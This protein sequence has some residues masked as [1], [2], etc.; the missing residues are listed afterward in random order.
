MLFNS[1]LFIK[2][3]LPV[4]FLY[5]FL[6]TK[7]QNRLLLLASYI[8]YGVWDWRFLPL[9][10]IPTV[11][12]YFCGFR[13]A[14]CDDAKQKKLYLLISIGVNLLVLGFFKY[15]NFFLSNI[16]GLLNLFGISGQSW[17]L[18]I[19]LPLGISFYTFK[20][21]SY[22]IDIYRGNLKPVR[23]LVDYALFV[24]F[25]IELVAGPIDRARN[26]LPQISAK[27][28]LSLDQVGEGCH[29][30]FWG[31]F[32]KVF[33]AGNLA[34]IVDPVFSTSHDFQGSEVL[35][36]TYAFAFQLLCDFSGYSN[37]A[38]GIGKALGFDIM[39]NFRTPFFV[40]NIQEFWKHW[41]ISLSSWV[42]DYVYMPLFFRTKKIKS[43]VRIHFVTLITM[44]IMGLW[45][46]A[47]WTFVV[48]GM[49]HGWL[50]VGYNI[51]RSSPI[52][53][54]QPRLAAFKFIW[55][56]I[57]VFF[58]FQLVALGMLLF[59]C[60]SFHQFIVMTQSLVYK[61]NPAAI[62]LQ[63]WGKLVAIISPFLIIQVGQRWSG[64]LMFLQKRNI[65]IKTF[66]YAVMTYLITGYGILKAEEFIYFQF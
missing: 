30:F 27:R 46:G 48:W 18:N 2:F 51:L 10:W 45:H 23:N 53:R 12:D 4:F 50:L 11:M 15:F 32:Q 42:N 41:H 5:L 29:L 55:T 1:L 19:I 65:F 17:S 34:R 43:R 63:D 31:L 47:S 22:T 54:V 56:I 38:Q 40:T 44:V 33:V 62:Q 64:D 26:L 58:V 14:A 7:W 8:F 16:Y 59:R 37:M 66:S 3:I 6:N 60:E 13:I 57:R 39:V 52:L 28:K 36:V 25:F 9:I 20:S 61:F 21:L 35:W 49:Y 24:A